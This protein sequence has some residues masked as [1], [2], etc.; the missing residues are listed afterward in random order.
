ML[1]DQSE[2]LV[3][4]YLVVQLPEQLPHPQDLLSGS[5]VLVLVPASVPLSPVCY[6]QKL[7]RALVSETCDRKFYVAIVFIGHQN[8]PSY[9]TML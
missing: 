3:S 5:Q 8:P 9:R 6:G 1:Y 7:A 2:D 4:A